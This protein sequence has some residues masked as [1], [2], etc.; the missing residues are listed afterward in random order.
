MPV[1][2]VTLANLQIQPTIEVDEFLEVPSREI[3]WISSTNY[4]PQASLHQQQLNVL[5]SYYES[6]SQLQPSLSHPDRFIILP[7]RFILGQTIVP[8]PQRFGTVA[9]FSRRNDF[10]DQVIRPAKFGLTNKLMLV[11]RSYPALQGTFRLRL[12]QSSLTYSF[13]YL[14]Q[15]SAVRR[16][17]H[18]ADVPSVFDVV[19]DLVH[20]HDERR[21]R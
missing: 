12:Q 19:A 20:W 14:D 4:K 8:V 21:G 7:N 11:V 9:H 15:R 1:H 13:I 6:L 10:Q 18:Q 17:A 3:I 2:S 16:K 5:I